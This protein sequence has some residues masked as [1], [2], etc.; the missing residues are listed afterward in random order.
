MS[1]FRRNRHQ[2]TVV[3]WTRKQKNPFYSYHSGLFLSLNFY[4]HPQHPTG[5]ARASDWF[6]NSFATVLQWTI[7]KVQPEFSIQDHDLINSWQTTIIKLFTDQ[8]EVSVLPV[9]CSNGYKQLLY[10]SLFFSF[11]LL[12]VNIKVA[13]LLWMLENQ[14]DSDKSEE[15]GGY[16]IGW[17]FTCSIDIF[18]QAK[19][20][21]LTLKF[22][23]KH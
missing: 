19:E 14:M 20:M 10:W 5:T 1:C 11:L 16:G 8:P 2:Q 17:F 13:K 22:F 9:R 12:I 15:N 6:L 3:L 4:G 21:N 18:C 7:F 23:P